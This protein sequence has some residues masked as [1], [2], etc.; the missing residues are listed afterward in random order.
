AGDSCAGGACAEL[1]PSCCTNDAWCS[2]SS[3]PLPRGPT[4]GDGGLIGGGCGSGSDISSG[5]GVTKIRRPSISVRNQEDHFKNAPL[6]RTAALC[7]RSASGADT[8][9]S[10]RP[11]GL[12]VA[13]CASS[14]THAPC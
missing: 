14:R 6:S 8:S 7:G 13:D 9:E 12:C 2:V 1:L 5:E 11:S 3:A 10:G 4:A